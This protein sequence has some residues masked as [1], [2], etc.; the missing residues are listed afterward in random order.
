MGRKIE[1]S[2]GNNNLKTYG[3]AGQIIFEFSLINACMEGS[4][5]SNRKLSSSFKPAETTPLTALLFA[6]I[7][8]EAG[9]PR[10][11]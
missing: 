5:I 11:I 6:E 10:S 8:V 9:L 4:S 7:C 3:V 1:L 2:W